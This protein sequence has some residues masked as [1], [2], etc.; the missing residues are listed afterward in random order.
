MSF[1]IGASFFV[2]GAILASFIGVIA[3]RLNTGQSFLTGRSH[4]DACNSPLSPIALIPILSYFILRGRATCCGARLSLRAPLTEVLLGALFVGSYLMLGFVSALP[5]LLLSLSILLALVLYDLSHQILPY[6]LLSV[7]IVASGLTGFLLAPSRAAFLGS[8]LSAFLIGTSLALIHLL[9]RGRAMGLAD[10][11]LAFGLALL[12]G[13]VALSGFV[14]SFWVG[15]L[16]G[17]V[18]LL[19]R[20]RGSRMRVEVP[21]APFLAV[22]FL[23]AYFTQW[24]L[25]ALILGIGA[26]H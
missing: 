9:S 14:Y 25:F 15:A 23:L 21:F 4:C 18:L 24:N 8:L 7:F 5:L 11:P 26:S 16:I 19:G 20:P 13:P 1:L 3:E 22:G 12:V 6:S 10:A 2:L 17:I